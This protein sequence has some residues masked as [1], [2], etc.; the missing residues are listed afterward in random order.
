MAGFTA[1]PPIDMVDTSP[2]PEVVTRER[3]GFPPPA[4]ALRSMEDNDLMA[5]VR[6]GDRAA[7]RLLVERHFERIYA[8]AYRI[9]RHG[10]DAEDI[11]QDVFFRLWTG[12]ANW[13]TEGARLSTWLFRVT[14][15]RCI[16]YK[17]KPRAGSMEEIPELADDAPSAVKLIEQQ[18][19]TAMLRQAIAKLSDQ[20]QAALAL[21]YQQ[22]LSNAEAA[23]VLGISVNAVE[24]LLKRARKRLREL[25]RHSS[26][27]MGTHRE[28]I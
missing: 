15:N 13:R 16:D 17:R 14:V 26:G 10:A 11:A 1:A 28:G 21:F 22:D 2:R 7:Y 18:Q 4:V 12:R 9:V 25:L 8:L 24:S 3:P 23:E 27:G 20:Q 19:A 6:G 5:L